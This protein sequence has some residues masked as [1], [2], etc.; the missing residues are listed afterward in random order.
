MA[1]SSQWWVSSATE[2]RS[3]VVRAWQDH[4]K[5]NCRLDLAKTV[6]VR[7]TIRECVKEVVVGAA[8]NGSLV[9][10]DASEIIFH[11]W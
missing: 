3:V 6:D 7:K 10:V 11:D 8:E 1:P 5:C 2:K 4:K 9:D